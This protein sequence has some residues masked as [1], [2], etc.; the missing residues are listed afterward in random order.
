[1]RNVSPI[2]LPERRNDGG[3]DIASR[4]ADNL[5]EAVGATPKTVLVFLIFLAAGPPLG[6]LVFWAIV[7]VLRDAPLSFSTYDLSLHLRSFGVFTVGSYIFGGLQ[8]LFVAC[9]A[10]IAQSMSRAGL[11]PLL[12]IILASLFVS[13]AFAVFVAVKSMSLFFGVV[14][15]LF[16]GLHVGS[17]LLCWLICN[18]VLWPFRRRSANQAMA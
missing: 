3:D 4:A 8:A 18:T 12:P 7:I 5:S 6:I 16:L 17:G 2:A 11:V 10:A 15:L 13:A 14:P 9:V 1:M